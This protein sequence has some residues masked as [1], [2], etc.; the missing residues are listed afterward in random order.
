MHLPMLNESLPQ[1]CKIGRF[2]DLNV[3]HSAYFTK[4]IFSLHGI[5]TNLDQRNHVGHELVTH[6]FCRYSSRVQLIVPL[7]SL[8]GE[9]KRLDVDC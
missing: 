4:R 6:S 3:V 9:S 5:S 2:W 8:V 7:A 1:P